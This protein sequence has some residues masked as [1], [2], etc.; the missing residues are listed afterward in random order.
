MASNRV[1]LDTDLGSDIDDICA[2]AMLLRWPD[3][4]LVGITTVAE[5]KGRRAGYVRY[6]LDL[7]G[8]GDIPVAA[9]ADVSDGFYR[10]K[11]GF[12]ANERYWPER[13]APSPNAAE[14]AI[15]LLKS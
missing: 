11:P 14:E 6:A 7:E 4:E 8:K 2:L 13:I 9:G 15:E 1:H 3:V 5:D 12:P 10:D